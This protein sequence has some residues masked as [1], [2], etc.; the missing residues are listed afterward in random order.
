MTVREAQER[1]SSREFAEWFAHY[2]VQP[3]GEFRADQ[4]SACESYWSY[5][6]MCGSDGVKPED[7]MLKQGEKQEPQDMEAM[8]KALAT[9][10]G[11]VE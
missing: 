8:F 9:R 5:V 4:R 1:I 10:F 11:K 3:F 7:F 6:S 2:S